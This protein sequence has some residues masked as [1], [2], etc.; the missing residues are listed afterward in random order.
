M[1]VIASEP[2]PVEV[3]SQGLLAGRPGSSWLT[4]I[5]RPFA[6]KDVTGGCEILRGVA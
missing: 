3:G 2:L 5:Y 4:P 1:P 6:Q